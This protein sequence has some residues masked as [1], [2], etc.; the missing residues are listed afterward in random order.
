MRVKREGKGKGKKTGRKGEKGN[1]IK[2]TMG[3]K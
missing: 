1:G 3:R 2:R